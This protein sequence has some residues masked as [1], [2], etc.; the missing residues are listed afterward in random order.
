[1]CVP[2][3]VCV[4]VQ[5]YELALK[6]FQKAAEQGW[7][8]GQLQLGTMYYSECVCVC[9][10]HDTQLPQFKKKTNYTIHIQSILQDHVYDALYISDVHC[11]Q[12]SP[13][14]DFL[15]AIGPDVSWPNVFEKRHRPPR[16][17]T[18]HVLPGWSSL[19]LSI[20]RHTSLCVY[21]PS[22]FQGDGSTV[23][24]AHHHSAL[25]APSCL[26]RRRCLISRSRFLLDRSAGSL[27][28]LPV[29]PSE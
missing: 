25:S 13:S 15:C 7:V 19:V 1:M 4:C 8:D 21:G 14:V 26:R 11:V 22:G 29:K 16:L 6:Y 12:C 3:Y 24:V 27:F 9:A 28:P 23:A 20:A 10:P 18:V 2:V 17:G 5:N